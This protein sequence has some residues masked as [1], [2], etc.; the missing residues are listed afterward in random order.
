MVSG[1]R[2]ATRPPPTSTDEAMRMGIAFVMPTR[3][4]K[5]RFPNTADS[6]HRALQ[7]PKPVP[8]WREKMEKRWKICLRFTKSALCF[9][10]TCVF[11]ICNSMNHTVSKYVLLCCACWP[12]NSGE[13]FSSDHIQ[14]VPGRDAQAVV[15]AQ[16]ENH[17][18]LTGAE[19]QEETADAWKDHGA[20]WWM[21]KYTKSEGARVSVQG[22]WVK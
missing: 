1:N 5:I 17:H 3:D 18:G 15:K 10:C 6:L 8:L 16:H 21:Y 19:P 13:W 12:P 7:N 11:N 22:H 20:T 2:S 9:I 14:G 4:P